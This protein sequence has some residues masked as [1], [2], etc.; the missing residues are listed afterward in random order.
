MDQ[1]TYLD[2]DAT[3]SRIR[4]METQSDTV[5]QTLEQTRDIMTELSRNFEGVSASSLQNSY[6][7]VADTFADLRN[8]FQRKIDELDVLTSN[9]T[10]TDER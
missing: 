5:R 9:I 8:Y 2:R 7:Q 3:I 4:S 6:Q 10:A 1:N